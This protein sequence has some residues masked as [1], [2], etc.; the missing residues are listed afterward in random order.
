M[1]KLGFDNYIEPLT[2]YLHRYCELDSSDRGGSIKGEQPLVKQVV[3]GGAGSIS[4]KSN[5]ADE[6][7]LDSPY[8]NFTDEFHVDLP[9][10][11]SD[12]IAL[13]PVN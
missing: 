13:K 6:L 3:D 7:R 10:V 5:F 9:V 12:D 11:F 2:V 4:I 8:L 1:S